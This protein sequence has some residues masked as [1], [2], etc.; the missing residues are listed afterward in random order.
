[1]LKHRRTQDR[2][3]NNAHVDNFRPFDAIET[4]HAAILRVETI[5]QVASDAVDQLRCPSAPAARRAFARMQIL[6]AKA[7]DEATIA[8]A[9]GDKLVAALSQHVQGRSDPH[10]QRTRPEHHG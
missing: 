2:V 10:A 3:P 6:V 5:A 7:A 9:E 4:L 8:L 1:M